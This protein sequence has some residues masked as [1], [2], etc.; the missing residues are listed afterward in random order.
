VRGKLADSSTR[1]A[2]QVPLGSN[3]LVS[4]LEVA[5]QLMMVVIITFR[6]GLRK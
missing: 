5:S 4:N 6:S 3:S 1:L 2:D